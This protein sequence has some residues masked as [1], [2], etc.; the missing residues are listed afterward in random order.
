MKSIM[1]QISGRMKEAFSAAGYDP[2]YGEVK[3]SDRPDLCEYQCNGAMAAAKA[4]HKAPF[5]IADDVLDVTSTAQELGKSVGKDAEEAKS[6]WVSLR[7][8]EQ[9]RLDAQRE[10]ELALEAIAPLGSA[11]DFFAECAR[12]AVNR[13][14]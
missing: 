1:E 9:A 8:L 2:K 3:V 5:Q 7:G 4:Y 12:G 6:T 11:A 10:A 13:T 14:H